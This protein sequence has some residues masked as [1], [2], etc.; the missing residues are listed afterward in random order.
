MPPVT[1]DVLTPTIC[2]GR[3]GVTTWVTDDPAYGLAVRALDSGTCEFT[4]SVDGT[5]TSFAV[6]TEIEA[7][8]VPIPVVD[9]CEGIVCE[10]APASCDGR[11]RAS[12]ARV[13]RRMRSGARRGR[14]QGRASGVGRAVREPASG[15]DGLQRRRRLRARSAG[16]RLSQLLLRGLEYRANS[17]RS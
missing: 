9:P 4:V 14:V 10:P 13:L 6:Q 3:D 1:I 8:D 15:R 12:D 16:R 2:D 7:T 5:E 11:Q 17:R